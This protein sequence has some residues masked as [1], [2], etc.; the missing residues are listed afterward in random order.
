MAISRGP[1]LDE[2]YLDNLRRVVEDGGTFIKVDARDIQNSI[3]GVFS[4]NPS[5]F[6][7]PTA[8]KA[9]KLYSTIPSDGSG[10]IEFT[11]TGTSFHIQKD[12]KIVNFLTN[13]PIFDYT[14]DK[15]GIRLF[16]T[17]E[18]LL[19][20]S[21]DVSNSNWIKS[22]VDVSPGQMSTPIENSTGSRVEAINANATI[23]QT[24]SFSNRVSLFSVFIRKI[25][26]TGVIQ[27]ETSG[28]I[29]TINT[30]EE[31]KRYQVRGY[32]IGG[33]FN[34]INGF[35]TITTNVEHKLKIGDFV[36]FN[37]INT[38]TGP[39][40]LVSNIVDN[41]TFNFNLG[42]ASDE[43][44]CNIVGNYVNITLPTSGDI[45]EIIGMQVNGSGFSGIDD[46]RE[47][48]LDF[49]ND[50]GDYVRTTTSGVTRPAD[51][52]SYSSD[53]IFNQ[54]EG[55]F[56]IEFSIPHPQIGFYR[57]A[58]YFELLNND[59]A[60]IFRLENLSAGRTSGNIFNM[61]FRWLI[62]P[63][64][65]RTSNTTINNFSNIY[66]VA[67]K[68]ESNSLKYFMNGNLI[69]NITI[70]SQLNLSINR[71]RNGSNSMIVH[72]IQT[73]QRVLTDQE[74]SI[75]TST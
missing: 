15:I 19:V 23:R 2:G 70:S 34:S 57:V 49:F 66:K 26:G 58:N 35:Y 16:S 45:F 69:N 72:S 37:S 6:M 40:V 7:V 64:N 53:S 60:I 18:N 8:G 63:T 71:F 29:E 27:I 75:I 20:H 28:N 33:N 36:K 9:G 44:E 48:D 12:N 50:V 25:S 42:N 13:I 43:G 17:N 67:I 11:R 22:D 21:E 62:V 74:A 65:Q 14:T 56:F 61:F 47:I 52:I 55:T 46:F 39:A 4:N 51:F 5:L 24:R 68:W 54:N 31:Y 1:A 73:F 38:F 41:N 10:D 32:R 30:S 3:D 59:N